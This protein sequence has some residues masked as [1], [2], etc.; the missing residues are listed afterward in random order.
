M[1]VCFKIVKE[2]LSKIL[3]Y[4]SIIRSS[5]WEDEMCEAAGAMYKVTKDQQYL[6][7]AKGY[8]KGGAGWAYSWDAKN[9]G[10]QVFYKI[11]KKR[12]VAMTVIITS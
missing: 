5:G 2:L 11:T 4:L 8:D 1:F 9:A 3:F 12:L 10:C 7:D 6:N